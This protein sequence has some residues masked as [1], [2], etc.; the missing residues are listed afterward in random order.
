MMSRFEGGAA[1]FRALLFAVG[2]RRAID[3]HRHNGRTVQTAPVAELQDLDRSGLARATDTAETIVLDKLTA[4]RAIELLGSSLPPEQADVVL[5]RV[6]AGLSVNEVAGILDKAP[7]A[8]RSAQYRAIRK[9][10]QTLDRGS[11]TL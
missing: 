1:D 4:Q 10:Q 5:L 11:V 9:L 6:V 2:R 3:H 7:E 8:I